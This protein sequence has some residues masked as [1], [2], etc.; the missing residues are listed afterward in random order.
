MFLFQTTDKRAAITG[1][2]Q[3]QEDAVAFWHRMSGAQQVRNEPLEQPDIQH[4]P[5]YI[6]EYQAADG[7]IW[8]DWCET[9]DDEIAGLQREV[10]KA[11]QCYFIVYVVKNDW[12]GDPRNPGADYMGALE[13]WHIDNAYLDRRANK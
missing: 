6:L 7:S 13:H 10:L 11:G 8:Y 2:F 3:R 4:F 9:I 1:I 5:F 12:H